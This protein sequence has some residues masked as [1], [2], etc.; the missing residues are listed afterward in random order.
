MHVFA[1]KSTY[2]TGSRTGITTK[3]NEINMVYEGYILTKA[4]HF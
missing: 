1:S 3:V 4:E 2:T